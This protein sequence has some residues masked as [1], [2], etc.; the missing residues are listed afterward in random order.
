M[1]RQIFTVS[2]HLGHGKCAV[3]FLEPHGR[4][5]EMGYISKDA[6]AKF[7]ECIFDGAMI[8][9]FDRLAYAIKDDRTSHGK[10]I[11]DV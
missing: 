5:T 6:E 8:Y 1:M 11:D 9:L 10:L 7:N 3:N 2:D 4:V